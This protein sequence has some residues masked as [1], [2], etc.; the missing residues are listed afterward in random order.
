MIFDCDFYAYQH[1]FSNDILTYSR[2]ILAILLVL[3]SFDLA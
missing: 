3:N 1:S 2:V